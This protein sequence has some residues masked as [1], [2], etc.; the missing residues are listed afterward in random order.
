METLGIEELVER[1]VEKVYST[2]RLLDE[3]VSDK[4]S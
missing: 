3:L 2:Y 1:L 4:G